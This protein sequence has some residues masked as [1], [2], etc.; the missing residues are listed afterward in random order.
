MD[1]T[2][3]IGTRDSEL[4]MWQAKTVQEQLEYLGYKTE[5]VPI[6][7]TGDLVLNKPIYEL[8]ITGVFTRNLDISMLNNDI[9]IAVHSL[10][11]VPTALP[12]GIVQAAVLKR[13]PSEDVLVFKGNEEFLAQKDAIIATGSLRRKAQWLH[14]YPSHKIE[15]LRGNVNTRLQK[16]KDNEQLNG[17]IFAA[18]GLKRIGVKP[19]N[20]VNLSWMVSAPG[21]GAIMIA[22]LEED[23]Y[24]KE[25]CAKLNHEETEICTNVERKFLRLLEGGCSS[26]I[27]ALA[28]INEKE[29]EITFKGIILSEDG[30]RKKEVNKT[31]KTRKHI[32]LAQDTADIIIDRGGKKLISKY[33]A[34]E[35]KYKI[36]STKKF[37]DSQSK[38][39][40]ED[41]AVEDSDFI[42]IRSSRIPLPVLKNAI[43]NVIITSKNAIESL[44][45]NFSLAALQFKNI[46]CVGRRTKALIEKKIGNVKFV[47]RNAKLLAK[48]LSE[49]IKGQEVTYF[50]SSLRLDDLPTILEQNEV[51]VNEV[52][53]YKTMFS[54]KVIDDNT[55]G[56]LFY[57]PST[58]ESYILENKAIGIAFCIGETTAAKAK[59]HF[60][61]VKVA[62]VPTVES[63]IELANLYFV[64]K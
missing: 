16:L 17:A 22:A 41:I 15:G 10:K 46:Y 21:Q 44:E 47:A 48:H 14:R 61:E 24:C 52:E 3:R 32:Y 5:L 50:T 8:G 57:S 60:T 42:K 53:A 6:K 54:P 9:D 23:E 58:V 28:Y 33:G 26:P 56:V 36:C 27:G 63:V 34:F 51:V 55:D 31:V 45:T 1:K 7:A 35:K 4:A 37:T 29:D 18:A 12:E 11:D 25:A 19:E 43:E 59:K 39:V 30:S 40:H 13:G 49:E 38:L 20:M 62:K 2:I 64:K